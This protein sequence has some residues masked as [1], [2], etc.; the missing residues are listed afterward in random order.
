MAFPP[1]AA[2]KR[3][4][5][6]DEPRFGVA[7]VFPSWGQIS[8]PVD[9]GNQMSDLLNHSQCNTAWCWGARMMNLEPSFGAL[10]AQKSFRKCSA[11]T[12]DDQADSV[13]WAVGP[14]SFGKLVQHGIAP[15]PLHT[16]GFNRLLFRP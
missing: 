6:N 4:R 13:L 2:L 8:P 1:N 16:L 5:D 15:G 10:R 12:A 9:T 3:M 11:P 7:F 14:N